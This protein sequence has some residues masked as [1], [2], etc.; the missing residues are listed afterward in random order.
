VSEAVVDLVDVHKTYRNGSLEVPALRGV[1]MRVRRGEYVA[2]MGPSGSGKSTLMNILGC[3]DTI[4]SGTYLLDGDDVAELDE[5]DLSVIRNQRIGFI[6]QQFNLLPALSAWRNVELPLCYAGVPRAERRTRALRALERVG[7]GPRVDH[8]PGELS[9]GQQ[10]RVAVARAL[11]GDPAIILA[12]EP[13]GNLDSVSTADVLALIDELHD[14]GRTVIVI[15]HEA[16]VGERADRIVH[17][18]DGLVD[19]DTGSP[20]GHQESAAVLG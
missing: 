6:F 5:E 11:V 10:Q 2:V 3:L 16:E 4:T 19:D 15:T 17:V 9:G 20:I 18:R 12:D 1:T 8:R 14:G 7:L 13:T